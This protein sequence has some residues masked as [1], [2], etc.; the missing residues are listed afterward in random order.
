MKTVIVTA[1]IL[2]FLILLISEKTFASSDIKTTRLQK[3]M[4]A[5][6]R[7]NI[8]LAN[9][10]LKRNLDGEFHLPTFIFI[11]KA[12]KEKNEYLKTLRV[13]YHAIK[14][15]HGTALLAAA[16]LSTLRERLED[17][18]P[19]SNESLDLYY[20]IAKT[21][22]AMIKNSNTE[23]DKSWYRKLAIK[24]FYICNEYQYMPQQSKYNLGVLQF[25]SGNI[26]DKK[27]AEINFQESKLQE[28]KDTM[29]GISLAQARNDKDSRSKFTPHRD[30][31][32]IIMLRKTYLTS[33]P[34]S[35][36]NLYATNYLDQLA[37]KTTIFDA[38]FKFGRHSNIEQ[39][40]DDRYGSFFYQYEANALVSKGF[41]KYWKI[42]LTGNGYRSRYYSPEVVA[43]GGQRLDGTATLQYDHIKNNLIKLIYKDS[44]H[45]D[46]D[47]R[48]KLE[49]TLMIKE[50]HP[51]VTHIH[52][53]NTISYH[54]IYTK[55]QQRLY[56]T[57]LTTGFGGGISYVPFLTT[58][59]FAPTYELFLQT[60]AQEI[61]ENRY[62]KL[63]IAVSNH[64]DFSEKLSLLGELRSG[65]INSTE[66]NGNHHQ[67]KL[68]LTCGP[69]KEII[70][71]TLEMS[72][73]KS[74]L[75]GFYPN[76]PDYSTSGLIIVAG[77][78]ISL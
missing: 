5:Y 60:Y 51:V 75:P 64:L 71:T 57:L 52:K 78:T 39:N 20:L 16:N 41:L 14:L 48:N 9:R 27:N 62:N 61:S 15:N 54:L 53:N 38:T 22:V 26:V 8:H 4:L 25:V 32:S 29:L 28:D 69:L 24:Y 13:Y 34:G 36:L 35:A 43:T 19:P 18:T 31:A 46:R 50:I 17:T 11:A 37:D 58:K 72:Y 55:E 23:T 67:I 45:Y 74:T 68:L 1:T 70:A 76:R 3:A 66:Q 10:Y 33:T 47:S 12:Y 56:S 6:E 7:G 42:Y 30:D 21:Y 59:F 65:L 63:T 2:L 40:G 77:V 49:R 73:V 44:S